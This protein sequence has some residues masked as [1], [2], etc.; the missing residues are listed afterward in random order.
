[1]FRFSR[2]IFAEDLRSWLPSIATVTLVTVLVGVS[3]NQFAWTHNEVFVSEVAMEGYDVVEFR[4]VSETIY[5]LVAPLAFLALTVVGGATV[6]RVRAT[7]AQWR[8]V[9][10]SPKQVRRS[11]WTIVAIA[12]GI[13]ASAGSILAIPLSYA[14]IPVFNH[15]AVAGFVGPRFQPSLAAWLLSFGAS[16]MTCWFGGFV[17]AIRASKVEPVEV[18]RES[19]SHRPKMWWRVVLAV[20]LLLASLGLMTASAFVTAFG[21]SLAALFNLA[22]NAGMMAVVAVYLLGPALTGSLL[23]F[24][25]RGAD[26]LGLVTAT[27][28]CRAAGERATTSTNTLA[29]LAAGIGG[30]GVLA[31]SAAMSVRIIRATGY[32]G[33]VNLTDTLVMLGV[34]SL[35][36]LV[37]SAAVVALSGRDVEREQS[38]LRVAGM[39]PRVVTSW[40]AWQAV[41]LAGAAVIIALVPIVVTVATVAIGTEALIGHVII[42]VPWPVVGA[43]F[44]V[45]SIV[46]FSIMCLPQKKHLGE[47]VAAGLRR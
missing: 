20:L 37:T 31:A 23:R 13:G 2:L 45:S 24:F 9:G 34:V 33:D 25:A 40:Y 12:A 6:D 42:V 11:A 21:A 43:G 4:I 5:L 44:A 10:A 29:P 30:A 14:L 15:M 47:S 1:M 19:S 17:P 46:L 8:L 18:F 38:L 36:C 22:L 27:V 7:F 35:V 28:A 32:Q 3:A 41:V 16:F 39:S 26:A